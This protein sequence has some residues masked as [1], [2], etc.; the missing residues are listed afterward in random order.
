MGARSGWLGVRGSV[1]LLVALW[2]GGL[3]SS[4]PASES[5][6][7]WTGERIA[8]QAG[9]S[10]G[11]PGVA[12]FCIAVSYDASVGD[13]ESADVLA[14]RIERGMRSQAG[15][16]FRFVT[17]EEL[18]AVLA[19]QKLS[20]SDISAGGWNPGT[21]L[22][23][24]AL[25]IVRGARVFI[26]ES[27]QKEQRT[28]TYKSGTQEV[29]N[30]A[31]TQQSGA[32]ATAKADL[33]AAVLAYSQQ[34]MRPPQVVW[35][36]L[37]MMH[38][39]A[40]AGPIGPI[41]MAFA[42]RD[43]YNQVVPPGAQFQF[44]GIL[45]RFDTWSQKDQALK[46][47]PT[48]VRQDVFSEWRYAIIT[49]RLDGD[50]SG[51]VRAVD[52]RT[53]ATITSIDISD[54]AQAEDRYTENP[55][56]LAGVPRDQKGLLTE[57]QMRTQLLTRAEQKVVPS[58]ARELLSH[59]KSHPP[60]QPPRIEIL[61]PKPG[62][63][64]KGPEVVLEARLTDEKRVASASLDG[65]P[66]V[67]GEGPVVEF[68]Q[69]IRASEGRQ[70]VTIS[71]VD[72]AGLAAT[73]T[74]SFVVDAAPRIRFLQP[75]E[76]ETVSEPRIRVAAV[77]EDQD[78]IQWVKLNGETISQA[79]GNPTT[80]PCEV[81]VE[82]AQP[83]PNILLVEAM[84]AHDNLA[85]A[86]CEVR[87]DRAP[88]VTLLAPKE[89]A[90]VTTDQVEV[91]AQIED[92]IGLA[93]VQVGDTSVPVTDPRNLQL[94]ERVALEP[95]SNTIVV[96]VADQAGSVA[97]A[98]VTVMG[99]L[100]PAITIASTSPG[101]PVTI[102]GE[103]YCPAGIEI[104]NVAGKR[105]QGNGTQ[106][107]EFAETVK[108][109]EGAEFLKVFAK[110]L[111]GRVSEARVALGGEGPGG[112]AAKIAQVGE[113]VAYLNVGA[114]QGVRVGERFVV[115]SDMEIRDPDT[116]EVLQRVR[117]SSRVAELVVTEVFEKVSVVRIVAADPAHPL[118]VGQEAR[119]ATGE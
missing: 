70:S 16:A 10:Q 20:I 3:L 55:N 66:L 61:A 50:I 113:G 86:K 29:P 15:D 97:E 53:G 65:D 32:A 24:H 8:Q 73:Q 62:A 25:V 112:G 115:Y 2:C 21:V 4:P 33:D 11:D 89:G 81:D 37:Q 28:A 87:W 85:A 56:E 63:T 54:T 107:V 36:F 57:G 19:E 35:D 60:N 51:T 48:T 14:A 78:G 118:E 91:R 9:S 64:V 111:K 71:C 27:E 43:M 92:D 101:P 84:D 110:D 34:W 41:I 67:I 106:R 82:L 69:T 18:D 42:G 79:A 49:A 74:V 22:P 52:T 119:R 100:P 95:G 114:N 80:A 58:L 39:M 59:A 96:K 88:T 47:I 26:R 90:I 117:G 94:A 30:P 45:D 13:R 76:G 98:S 93:T 68:T 40:N 103:V 6:A 108:A 38:N 83:G 31:Y 5:Q 46:G 44:Q 17:R 77:V 75:Q 12:K 23:A 1:L 109:P 99:D 7:V 104:V 102:R 105:I 72:E 116:G